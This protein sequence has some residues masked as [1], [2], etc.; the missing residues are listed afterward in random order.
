MSS[1]N[2]SLRSSVS[3]NPSSSWPVER[4]PR[5]DATLNKLLKPLA[6]LRLTVAL[7]ALS[8][9]LIFT[10]TTVQS[11]LGVWDVQ[12]IYFHSWFCFIEW[13]LFFPLWD[14]GLKNVPGAI[15]FPGGYTII[16]ALL[17][18]LLAAHTVRFKLGWKRAGIFMIHGGLI[19]LLIGEIV[20]SQLA[21]ES[22]MVID[23]GSSSNYTSDTRSVE[24]AV[25]DPSPAD[26]NDEVIIPVPRL[27]ERG[28]IQHPR[29]PFAI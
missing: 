13:R 24:L 28:T 20:T 12:R 10:G 21:V 1:L 18:N 6:S 3:S 14:W 9:I 15:P 27:L 4:T 26:H 7:L 25:T 5:Q 19:L 23:V 2:S 8:M 29:L 16:A 17:V 22:Q 11:E